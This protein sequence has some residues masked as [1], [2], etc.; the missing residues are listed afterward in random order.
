[1]VLAVNDPQASSVQTWSPGKRSGFPVSSTS[2]LFRLS[3]RAGPGIP[4]QVAGQG[5]VVTMADVDERRRDV[6]RPARDLVRLGR[7]RLS[8][9]PIIGFH[10][11]GHLRQGVLRVREGCRFAQTGALPYSVCSRPAPT[12]RQRDDEA[13][14]SRRPAQCPHEL[15]R[16][17]SATSRTMCA[18][19]RQSS[20]RY[21]SQKVDQRIHVSRKRLA[22]GHVSAPYR[23]S[24]DAG[25]K[26]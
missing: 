7:S 6:L 23:Y 9:R 15:L 19:S 4:L 5:L 21:F 12:A 1:M 25:G 10:A 18:A 17:R 11:A 26:E 24:R 3:P 13:G 2:N 16:F 22:V 14:L 20:G 8:Q